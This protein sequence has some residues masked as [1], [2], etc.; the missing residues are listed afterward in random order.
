MNDHKGS[1]QPSS[2]DSLSWEVRETSLKRLRSGP[3]PDG[4]LQP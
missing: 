3:D 4:P 2:S 1:T